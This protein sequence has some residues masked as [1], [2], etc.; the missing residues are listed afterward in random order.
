MGTEAGLRRRNG[1]I[2][3]VVLGQRMPDGYEVL[4][5]EARPSI[6]MEGQ[7]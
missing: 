5:G 7:L 3:G 2:E 4:T 1:Q 6:A